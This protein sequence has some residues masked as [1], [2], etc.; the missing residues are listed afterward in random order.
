MGVPANR[1]AS[2]VFQDASKNTAASKLAAR[3]T[4]VERARMLSAAFHSKDIVVVP[5]ALQIRP[6]GADFAG[7]EKLSIEAITPRMLRRMPCLRTLTGL[8]SEK[9]HLA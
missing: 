6:E 7:S 5:P 3:R 8:V 2:A 1:T 9:L 4:F